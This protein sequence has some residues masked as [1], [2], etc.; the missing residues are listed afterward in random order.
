MIE[1]DDVP[2]DE[3]LAGLRIAADGAA[4]QERLRP[5]FGAGLELL[6]VKVGRLAYKP[7]RSARIAY[8]LKLFD[9]ERE[10]VRVHVL[11]GRMEPMAEAAHLY[12]KM[13]KRAW[14]QPAFGPALLYFDD[15][16]L[17]LW[18]FPND[19]KLPGVE[20]VAGPGGF[21][22]LAG[23]VPALH[24]LSRCDSTIVK[25]VPGKRLVMRHRVVAGERRRIVYT[26]TWAHD[27]GAAIHG[28]MRDLWRRSRGDERAFA[29]PQPLAYL[30]SARTLVLAALP[31]TAALGALH[32]GEAT[33]AMV[34]AGHGLARLH[35]GDA[36]GL[37]PWTEAHEFEN[38]L[39]ATALL[40]RH[41]PDLAPAVA[42][43]RAAAEAGRT[44]VEALAAMP[45]HTAFRFS[46]L[47]DFRGRLAIVDF[48]GFRAGH[49]MCDAGSFVAHL[50]Y[51]SA[52]DELD[53]DAARTAVRDFVAAYR[54]AA[55]WGAP[56]AALQWYTAV[57]L[58]AK[59]AQKCVKRMKADGDLKVQR[60]IARAEALLAGHESLG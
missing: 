15:L 23:G 31:G 6:N 17:V 29:S 11:H 37:E 48:D 21:A 51:M 12:A 54:E 44:R 3:S 43:L 9:R 28:V 55:P 49:P 59:H 52:K 46:Q 2:H 41:D 30:D 38:F 34:Q 19:P 36:A 33:R 39:A 53:A 20:A 40:E 4:M 24:G 50:L 47:L 35:A 60:L 58:V 10:Q 8:R 1:L 27:R 25:Y 42:R 22:A 13:R 5:H 16:G 7:R 45:I 14:A 18:G 56:P 57:I 32:T 26:K